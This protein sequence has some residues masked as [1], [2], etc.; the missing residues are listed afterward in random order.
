MASLS[1]KTRRWSQK[2]FSMLANYLIW[3]SLLSSLVFNFL[4]LSIYWIPAFYTSHESVVIKWERLWLWK[5]NILNSNSCWV[6]RKYHKWKKQK[7]VK[8]RELMHCLSGEKMAVIA[9]LWLIIVMKP[10][11]HWQRDSSS[12]FSRVEIWIYT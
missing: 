8:C 1:R 10:S 3:D 5:S 12:N 9:Q 2:T 7:N 6:L 4:Q 11:L